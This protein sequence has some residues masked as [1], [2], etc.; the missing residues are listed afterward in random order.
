MPATLAE[1]VIPERLQQLDN[2]EEFL[3]YQSDDNKIAVFGTEKDFATVCTSD[4][5]FVDE[6]F[7]AVPKFFKHLF[8]IRTFDG[9]KQYPR[10]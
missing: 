4:E 2:V 3:L 6:T 1:F 9:E 7:D 8:T 10:L 5:L